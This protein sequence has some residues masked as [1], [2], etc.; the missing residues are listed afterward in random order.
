MNTIPSLKYLRDRCLDSIEKI[1]VKT[2]RHMLIIQLP[3]RLVTQGR[4]VLCE[5]LLLEDNLS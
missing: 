3:A 5:C 2:F 1:V 4:A